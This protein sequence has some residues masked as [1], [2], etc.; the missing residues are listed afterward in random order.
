[1]RVVMKR[2]PQFRTASTKRRMRS[3]SLMP[4][5]LSTPLATS[6]AKGRTRFTAAPTFSG[7][8]PPARMSGTRGS[9]PSR[10]SHGK[11]LPGAAELA[12]DEGVDQDRDRHRVVEVAA[13]IEQGPDRV[14]AVGMPDG[15]RRDPADVGARRTRL[16][17]MALDRADAGQPSPACEGGFPAFVDRQHHRLDERRQRGQDVAGHRLGNRPR[18]LRVEVEADRVD[19]GLDRG[20]G[21]VDGRDAAD[22]DPTSAEVRHGDIVPAV[23]AL[24]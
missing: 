21:G 5:R 20:Q 16:R 6:T 23:D 9:K 7:V 4:G 1:M 17:I 14:E 10:R 22:L 24:S 15:E 8:S 2:L 18:R 3:I 13:N 19:P 11:R 12:G